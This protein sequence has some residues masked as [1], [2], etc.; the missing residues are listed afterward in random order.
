M[1]N[2]SSRAT[3]ADYSIRL[4]LATFSASA[5]GNETAINLLD[6]H[7]SALANNAQ[8]SAARHAF[9]ARS[10]RVA[11]AQAGLLPSLSVGA[12][13][14]SVHT[15]GAESVI[16]ERRHGTLYRATLN[17][18]LLRLDRWYALEA[19]RAGSKQSRQALDAEEQAL[20]LECINA[21]FEVLRAQDAVAAARAE[22]R[23]VGRLLDHV[24]ARL[25]QGAANRPDVLDAQA[26]HDL[27]V[28]NTG[29]AERK[30]LDALATLDK[31]VG[32]P[33]NQ[34]AGLAHDSSPLVPRPGQADEWVAQALT[35]HPALQADGFAIDAAR[36][37][38]RQRKAAHAP[39][40]DAVLGYRHGDGQRFGLSGS[41]THGPGQRQIS[42]RTISLEL[43]IPLFNGGLDV[44]RTR[45]SAAL[46]AQREDEREERRRRVVLDVR[47]LHRAV[48]TDFEQLNARLR[49]VQSSQA[50]L[51]ANQVGQQLGTRDIADVMD[52]QK[53]YYTA[54]RHYN[55]A[56]Y[57][58]LI[59]H[60]KL[61][62][63]A[64]SLTRQDISEISSRLQ[65]TYNAAQDFAPKKNQLAKLLS[66]SAH[67]STPH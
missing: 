45:E 55:D 65:P 30:A 56:R 16:A 50:S 62:E 2:S 36:H 15:H 17:Q 12:Q 39:T 22:A 5:L 7:A 42:E 14:E 24:S 31:L 9:S 54:V 18:P 57:D 29:L 53:R 21:Y 33:V 47:N 38:H 11:Q 48:M 40:L 6:V 44:S 52:A 60:F 34:L 49:S 20:I 64:G 19:A 43:N 67:R 35:D 28:A 63:A 51:D 1:G 26:A 27:A 3:V 41:A 46:L 4:L 13:L 8:L 59:H 61:E 32:K 66:L 25:R 58:L 23:A 10:E 37:E